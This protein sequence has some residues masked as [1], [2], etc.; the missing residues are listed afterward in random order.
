M[1]KDYI[2][3]QDQSHPLA[4]LITI[5]CYGTWLHGDKRGS[6]NRKDFKTYGSPKITSNENW[7]RHDKSLLKHP[8]A[9]LDSK[10]RALVEDAI[11]N[12]CI[13]R[14]YKLFAIEVRTNHAHIVVFSKSKPELIM[15]SFKSYATRKLR[16]SKQI[17]KT[18]KVWSRHGSTRY[19]W[20]ERHIEVA[21]DYVINGQGKELPNFD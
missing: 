12:V 3:F 10:K 11:S 9:K 2:E 6:M 4:Y 17:S 8:P 14:G 13:H 7:N 21:V 18:A 1:K 15:N 16:E 20:N 5:R 19:L